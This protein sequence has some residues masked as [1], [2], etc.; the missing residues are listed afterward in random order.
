MLTEL[1]SQE[2]KKV[3]CFPRAT[4][5][6]ESS[7][8]DKAWS[9]VYSSSRRVRELKLSVSGQTFG[10]ER[11]IFC[12]EADGASWLAV[13]FPISKP[14]FRL[15]DARCGWAGKYLGLLIQAHSA[16]RLLRYPLYVLRWAGRND[17][18]ASRIR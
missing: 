11:S 13:G 7:W 18:F 3:G 15:S 14:S 17:F 16:G 5:K 1:F 4:A 6:R 10:S 8:E 2:V 12:G 9:W